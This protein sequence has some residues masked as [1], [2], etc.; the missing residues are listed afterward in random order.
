MI[1]KDTKIKL[2]K[3]CRNYRL[4]NNML[5]KEISNITNIPIWRLSKFECGDLNDYIEVL[6]VYIYMFNVDYNK[7]IKENNNYEVN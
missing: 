7:F 5:I 3:Y 4:N 6:N 1:S 2:G